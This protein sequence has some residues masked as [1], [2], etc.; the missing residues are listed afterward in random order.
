LAPPHEHGRISADIPQNAIDEALRSV[1]RL[2]AGTAAPEPEP[3]APDDALAR[4][5]AAV[6]A[7]L[8]LSQQTGRETLEKLREE[9]ERHL[10]AAADL[11][12]FKKR[13]A[14]E[15]EE[16]RRFGSEELVK[17]LFPVVD[18]LDRALAAAPVEDPLRRGLELVLKTLEEVL[19]RNGVKSFRA[20]GERFDPRVHEALAL[21]P[22]GDAAPGAVVDEH[23]RGFFLHD[24][25]VRPAMVTVAA[26]RPAPAGGGPAGP[27][28]GGA[29]RGG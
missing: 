3:L 26:A 25:L 11:D 27:G 24:R 8:E 10:R 7:Q 19:G 15:R 23:G 6:K 5:L 4:E 2:A 12:N 28:A 9:H 14:R 13:A 17:Q 18:G 29:P 21:V 22:G 20:R 16:T 1:E